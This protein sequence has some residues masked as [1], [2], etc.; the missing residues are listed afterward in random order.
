[1]YL[2]LKEQLATLVIYKGFPSSKTKEMGLRSFIACLI[3]NAFCL[4]SKI[5]IQHNSKI[6]EPAQD[7]S[8]NQYISFKDISKAC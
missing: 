8:S 5:H 1:M 3:H 4:N 7:H 2:R 6:K